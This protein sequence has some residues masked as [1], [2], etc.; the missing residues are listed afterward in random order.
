MRIEK[1]N[2]IVDMLEGKASKDLQRATAYH[3][4]YV[5]ACEDLEE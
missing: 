5:Q 3:D 2:E 1:I 4:G